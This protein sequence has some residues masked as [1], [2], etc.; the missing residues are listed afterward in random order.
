MRASTLSVSL[1]LPV[2]H[3]LHSISIRP[4]VSIT[5]P[6]SSSDSQS[7]EKGTVADALKRVSECALSFDKANIARNFIRITWLPN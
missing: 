6:L 7:E 2:S 1:S 4:S 3:S 5:Q